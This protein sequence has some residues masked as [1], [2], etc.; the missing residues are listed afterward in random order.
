MKKSIFLLILFAFIL[1]VVIANSGSYS[2]MGSAGSV[3]IPVKNNAI[4][5]EKEDI[6]I[7]VYKIEDASSLNYK[8]FYDCTF[9]FKNKTN[10][11]QDVTIGFPHTLATYTLMDEESAPPANHD[12]N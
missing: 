12:S 5:M 7:D 3:L 9:H 4:S 1:P 10:K 2:H 6:M 11:P 8:I